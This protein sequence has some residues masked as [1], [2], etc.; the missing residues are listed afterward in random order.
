MP[1]RRSTARSADDRI[2]R[3]ASGGLRSRAGRSVDLA[4][5]SRRRPRP[6]KSLGP[7]RIGRRDPQGGPARPRCT[8]RAMWSPEGPCFAVRIRE[9]E[10]PELSRKAR[11]QGRYSVASMNRR[12]R[13]VRNSRLR[14]ECASSV[15][16]MPILFRW[17]GL[18]QQTCGFHQT[19]I[20]DH[21]V[22]NSA[23]RELKVRS[24]RE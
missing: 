22:P 18:R 20:C 7:V 10:L 16:E 2:H 6:R 19:S 4:F 13:S 3:K 23:T 21:Q 24:L 8:H 15:L 5:A 1:K 12:N 11:N 14:F 9:P 17:K